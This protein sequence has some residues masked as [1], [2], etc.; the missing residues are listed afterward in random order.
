MRSAIRGALLLVLCLEGCG[1]SG[2]AQ[3][4]QPIVVTVFNFLGDPV[5]LSAGATPYGSITGSG[6]TVLSLP[7]GTRAL[8]WTVQTPRYSNGE[9]QPS[10]LGPIDVPVSDLGSV[11]INNVADGQAYYTPSFAN[12]TGDTVEIGIFNGS[13]V[14]CVSLLGPSGFGYARFAYF[15]MT[16]VSEFRYYRKH[17]G[18][19]GHYLFWGYDAIAKN[20]V[21]KT[22]AIS[23][24]G[25][26]SP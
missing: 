20:Y 2:P 7:G 24:L 26:Q 18:C 17:T 19:T 14:Q 22:G 3:P 23:L 10:D 21:A 13:S 15:R 9:A 1:D 11:D 5:S 4:P 8:R 6:K 12:R 16:A 25:S